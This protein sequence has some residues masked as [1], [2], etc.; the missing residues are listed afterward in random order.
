MYGVVVVV[1]WKSGSPWRIDARA[2]DFLSLRDRN[3]VVQVLP[4]N[5]VMWIPVWFFADFMVLQVEDEERRKRYYTLYRE[6]K[7]RIRY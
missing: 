2:R 5:K 1:V 7:G 3:M 6:E 4:G